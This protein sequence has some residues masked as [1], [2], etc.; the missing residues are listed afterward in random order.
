MNF[1]D[2]NTLMKRKLNTRL[3]LKDNTEMIPS[4]ST[5]SKGN[6]K[7]RRKGSGDMQTM[8]IW[9]SWG[10]R[11]CFPEKLTAAMI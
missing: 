9:N 7:I 4:K 2:Y 10:M 3:S 6:V 5:S 1:R 8:I 11:G